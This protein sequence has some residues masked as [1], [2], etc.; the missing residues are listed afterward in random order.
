MTPGEVVRVEIPLLPSGT[1]FRKG[2]S[3]RLYIQGHDLTDNPMIGYR[4]L[5]NK[6][7]HVIYT[8]GKYD[9]CLQIP[10]IPAEK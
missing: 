5:I 8:G 10:V 7:A 9:S 1:L 3:L 6:G 2:E 4:E